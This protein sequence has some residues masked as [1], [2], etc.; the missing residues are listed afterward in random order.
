MNYNHN[1][2]LILG[3]SFCADRDF[4][5]DWPMII[6]QQLAGSSLVPRGF[7]F[8]G[9]SWWSV[10]NRL[11]SEIDL[12]KPKI[13]ILC[14]TEPNRLPNDQDYGIN[15]RIVEKEYRIITSNGKWIDTWRQQEIAE[16]GRLYYKELWS[17]QFHKWAQISWFKELDQLLDT[18]SIPIVIH[19]HC[20][21]HVSYTFKNGVTIE[22]HLLSLAT[23]GNT[24]RNHFTEEMN[25]KIGYKLAD[26]IR[27]YT[28]GTQKLG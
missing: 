27:N 20:F 3:D 21:D 18:W 1:E 6:T 14:H 2:I 16:A 7:G 23:D 19:L 24:F 8:R 5:T 28:P 4:V 13:L 11:L 12:N 15:S 9:A 25:Q 17:H 10:R 26:I 22:E